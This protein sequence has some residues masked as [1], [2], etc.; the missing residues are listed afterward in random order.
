LVQIT[1]NGILRINFWNE[2]DYN[3]KCLCNFK[4]SYCSLDNKKK[5]QIAFTSYQLK[6]TKLLWNKLAK[7]NDKIYVR[8]NFNGE[9]LVDKWA[10]KSA[11]YINHIPNVEVF[12]IITNNSV[13]PKFYLDELDLTKTSFNCSYHP[14]CI[15]LQ[16]FLKNI[17]LLKNNGCNL[18]A[19]IVC[20]PQVIDKIPKIYKIFD[21]KGILLRLLAFRTD[22]FKYNGKT[23]P[24]DYTSK[25]RK[26]MEEYFYSKE[27]YEYTVE[28]KSTKNLNCYAGVDMINLF[29]DGTI[30]RCT[31]H[32]INKNIQERR[33]I[34]SSL[35]EK[36]RNS[37]NK[38]LEKPFLRN[39]K[40]LL[41]KI[42]Q[43][44][45]KIDDLITSKIKL[46]KDPYP[47]IENTCICI[48]HLLG[49]EIIRKKY[50]LSDHFVDLYELA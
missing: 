7:I 8:V 39:Y 50:S 48:A 31:T 47:C 25:E 35:P 11:F 14:E 23:Y 21:K 26:I 28:C 30:S 24:R 17:D 33:K 15:S 45:S 49:L 6:Q 42:N 16:Q 12:E 41:M 10:M 36:L 18:F 19:N 46:E 38:S 40:R 20:T 5:K 13:N 9:I 43:N 1:E 27:E 2:I 34:I 29:I 4:C 32:S 3:S 44:N 37:M 22:G